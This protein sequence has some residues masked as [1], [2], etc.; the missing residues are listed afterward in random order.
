MLSRCRWKLSFI[1]PIMGEESTRK[2]AHEKII[3]FGQNRCGLQILKE[4]SFLYENDRVT[5]MEPLAYIF[6]QA[7]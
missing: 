5:S 1:Q 7:C 4:A 2:H 3:I 6:H